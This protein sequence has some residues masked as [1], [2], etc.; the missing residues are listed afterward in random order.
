MQGSSTTYAVSG[1]TTEWEDILIKKGIT[2][3]EDVL[4]GKG[5]NPEDFLEKKPLEVPLEADEREQAIA[6]ADLDELDELEDEFTDSRALDVYRQQRLKELQEKRA[7]SRFGDVVEIAKDEWVREVTEGSAGSTWVVVHL[8]LD[9]L[10]E[11]SLLDEATINLAR[12]F[13]YVKFLKIRATSAVE[14]W[15]ER[16]CPTLFLYRDGELREQMITLNKIGGKSM[17]VADLEWWFVKK[18][19]I[20]D[21][22]LDEDPRAKGSPSRTVL[23]FGARANNSDDEGDDSS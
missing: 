21:S 8:Y 2:T 10:V 9:A 13:P 5:L 20:T 7:R 18:G 4:L 12:R 15:P 19:I 11:S 22:E 1:E 23:R 16:N 6:E 17:K 14:N 3:K